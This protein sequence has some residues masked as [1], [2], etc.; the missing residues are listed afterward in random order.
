LGDG[1]FLHADSAAELV[2]TGP[3]AVS[4]LCG[5]GGCVVWLSGGYCLWWGNRKVNG[6]VVRKSLAMVI[7]AAEG[8]PEKTVDI[9]I[10]G[11]CLS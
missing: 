9:E 4:V 8:V 5:G 7:T 2:S 6:K 1:V 3:G 10:V 11:R